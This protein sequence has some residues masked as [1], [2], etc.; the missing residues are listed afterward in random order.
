MQHYYNFIILGNAFLTSFSFAASRSS[1]EENRDEE[2]DDNEDVLVVEDVNEF[3]CASIVVVLLQLA[4]ESTFFAL[5]SV[6]SSHEDATL[7]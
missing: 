1:I 2:E 6:L 7:D 4:S 3:V 5:T